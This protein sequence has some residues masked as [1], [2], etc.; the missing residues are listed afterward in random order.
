MFFFFLFLEHPRDGAF[1]FAFAYA[2]ALVVLFFA[3]RKTYDKFCKATLAY[4]QFQWHNSKARL[5]SVFL[6][7][8]NHLGREYVIQISGT[9]AERTSKNPHL[10]TGDIEI[11]ADELRVL[12]ASEVPPFTIE[13]DTDGGDDLRMRYR[14]LDLRRA[15]VRCNIE[16]RHRMTMEVRR[17]GNNGPCRSPSA[18][19]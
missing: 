1:V 7:P 12:N 2:L 3:S 11:V 15:P 13:D 18:A 6:K 8:A 10:P 9:V 14:Y 19:A 4:E 17:Y 5:F 16:L